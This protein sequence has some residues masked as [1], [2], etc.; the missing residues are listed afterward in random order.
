MWRCIFFDIS[1]ATDNPKSCMSAWCT[2]DETRFPSVE[3]LRTFIR[4]CRIEGWVRKVEQLYYNCSHSHGLARR[5]GLNTVELSPHLSRLD[6]LAVLTLVEVPMTRVLLQ[7]IGRLKRLEELT[8]HNTPARMVPD[9]ETQEPVFRLHETPFP[10]LRQFVLGHIR[11]VDNLLRD[12]LCVLCGAP[13]LRTIILDNRK[14]LTRFLPLITPQLVSF[15]ADLTSVRLEDF[16]R[17]IKGHAALQNLIVH[18]SEVWAQRSYLGIDLDPA[19]LPD[20]R[21]FSGPFALSPKFIGSRPVTKLASPHYVVW[22]S[23]HDTLLPFCMKK[24]PM[25]FRVSKV[26][27]HSWEEVQD[28][29][30]VWRGLKPIGG[31]ISQ[32]FVNISG[33]REATL[34]QLGLCFPNLVHLQLEVPVRL[35]YRCQCV[36]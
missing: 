21:S 15:Y 3:T 26:T 7:S 28:N 29:P 14:W 13:T 35:V 19:D 31:G 16:C 20:L 32:L 2:E 11:G 18:F 24:D 1:V 17:F 6:N 36:S 10:A 34:S 23:I 30:E 9:V 8:I 5:Q 25:V 22:G 33:A 4:E 27:T 12:V